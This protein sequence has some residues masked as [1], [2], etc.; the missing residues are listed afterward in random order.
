[1]GQGVGRSQADVSD[2]AAMHLDSLGAYVE[3]EGVG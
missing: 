2:W 1:M 3:N